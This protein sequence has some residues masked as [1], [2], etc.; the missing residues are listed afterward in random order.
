MGQGRG[1]YRERTNRRSL[2]SL[3]FG[4]RGIVQKKFAVKNLVE[5]I[6]AVFD[7]LVWMPPSLQAK[8]TARWGVAVPGE[9]LTT[10]EREIVRNVAIGLKNAE[11]AQKLS[12]SEL[13]VKTHLNN[14]LQKLGVRDRVGLA[15][16]VLRAGLSA[17]PDEQTE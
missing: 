15:L 12:I 1:S 13:T 8:L 2:A 14:I 7:G 10:R 9:L 5:A 11:I 6:R 17:L 16:Y 4:A 3:R